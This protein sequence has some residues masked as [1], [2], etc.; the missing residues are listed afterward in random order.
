M[1]KKF[2]ELLSTVKN[3][4]VFGKKPIILKEEKKTNPLIWVLVAL[5]AVAAVA[6]IAYAVYYFLIPDYIEEFDEDFDDDEYEEEYF[7]DVPEEEQPAE[8]PVAE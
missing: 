5:G 2:E 1:E 8:A 6:A 4:E 7:V 3:I